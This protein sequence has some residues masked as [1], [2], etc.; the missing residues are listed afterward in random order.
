M[1]KDA[2]IKTIRFPVGTDDKLQKLADGSSLPDDSEQSGCG[3]C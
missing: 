3:G 2:N 1:S